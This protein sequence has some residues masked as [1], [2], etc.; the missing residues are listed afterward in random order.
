M[1]EWVVF[2][3]VRSCICAGCSFCSYVKRNISLVHSREDLLHPDAVSNG[4]PI[5][6]EPPESPA[7]RCQPPESYYFSA[8]VRCHPIPVVRLLDHTESPVSQASYPPARKHRPHPGPHTWFQNYSLACAEYALI[9]TQ[10]LAGA[11]LFQNCKENAHVRP[12]QRLPMPHPRRLRA[13]F[14]SKASLPGTT[15]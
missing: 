7:R 13:F 11:P 4:I 5:L 12:F 6:P 9:S 14:I 2:G 10:V 3:K 15:Y 1:S 8:T